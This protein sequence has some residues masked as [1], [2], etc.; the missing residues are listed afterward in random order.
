MHF[1]QANPMI[2]SI[3]IFYIALVGMVAMLFLK[4]HEVRTGRETVVSKLG[5]GSDHFFHAAFRSARKFVSY[6]NKRTFAALAQWVAYHILLRT[7]K[8]YVEV[9]HRA[10]QT[11]YGKR[12]IDAVRGR[13]EISHHG[14]SFYLRRIGQK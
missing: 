9:K 3:A 10:L 12:M 14:A 2:A 13:G 8:V 11:P 1:I 4:R 5:Q 7:R 6:F